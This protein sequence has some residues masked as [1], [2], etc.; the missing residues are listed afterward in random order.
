MSSLEATPGLYDA[1]DWQ[2][3]KTKFSYEAS[4]HQMELVATHLDRLSLQAPP[5]SKQIR[6]LIVAP[7][8]VSTNISA[9]LVNTFTSFISLLL[10]Y[11]VCSS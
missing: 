2:L 1:D 3:V 11:L 5:G 9:A 8:I 6:H 10:F 4:K 7:G